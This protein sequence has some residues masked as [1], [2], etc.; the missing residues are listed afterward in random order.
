MTVLMV[1]ALDSRRWPTLG[2]LVCDWIERNLVFGPGDKR[3]EQAVIDDEKRGLIYRM[4]ELFPKGHP[5]EG[6]RR[7]RRC[8]L[9][10]RKGSAKSELAGG[11]LAAAELHPRAPVR[12]AGWDSKGAPL[13]RG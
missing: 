9:S 12:F 13:G 6:R 10:L 11:W 2:P 8:A 4:Y 3:G 1:P 7:F 5:K